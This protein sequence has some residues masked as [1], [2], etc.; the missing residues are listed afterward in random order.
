M[1]AG[2]L[3]RGV[4]AAQPVLRF[5]HLDDDVADRLGNFLEPVRNPRRNHKHIAFDYVM[6]LP[7]SDVRTRP[8]T[9][10]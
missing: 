5:E 4:P 1:G 9:W 10:P 6:G 2:F 3:L 8:L 7:A